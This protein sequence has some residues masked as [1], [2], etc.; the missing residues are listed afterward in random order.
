MRTVR[1]TVT[2][3]DDVVRGLRAEMRRTGKSF[4]EVVNDAL[5]QGFALLETANT[6]PPFKVRAR[7]LGERPGINY[8]DTSELLDELDRQD[9]K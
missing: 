9:R 6:L 8:D 5:R 4:K 1:T 3:D 2:L 7:P